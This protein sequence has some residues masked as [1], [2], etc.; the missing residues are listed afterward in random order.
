[1]RVYVCIRRYPA[2]NSRAPY[3]LSVA[4][5]AAQCYPTLSHER[6]DFRKKVTEHKMCVLIFSMTLW[7]TVFIVR[8]TERDMIE[9]VYRFSCEV[10]VIVVR[11]SW[12]LNFF[13][14]IFFFQKYSNII[15]NETP[16]SRI[17]IVLCGRTGGRA[18]IANLIVAFRHFAE[19]T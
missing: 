1:M 2:C 18:D 7:A 8:R 6:Q 5:P 16:P 11:F 14:R 9:N 13:S 10:L 3:C 17:R 19:S 12:N 4:C 15:F